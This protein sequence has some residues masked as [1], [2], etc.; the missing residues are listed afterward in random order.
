MCG[1][2][3]FKSLFSFSSFSSSFFLGDLRS[4]C[5][6]FTLEPRAVD[7]LSHTGEIVKWELILPKLCAET[8]KVTRLFE[9]TLIVASDSCRHFG[10]RA[11][12]SPC[13]LKKH[14]R[15][16]GPYPLLF[17]FKFS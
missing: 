13:R 3:L 5:F 2:G 17:S 14:I 8:G 16:G 4:E 6:S 9:Q 7:C 10:E 1:D 11:P 12:L 15:F